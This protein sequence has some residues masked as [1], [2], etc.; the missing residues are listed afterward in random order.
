MFIQEFYS[1]MHAIN[2]SVPRFI[3]VFRGTCI[4]ITPEL[5]FEVLRV[6]SV[7]HPDFPSHHC[8]STIS[9]DKLAPLFREKVML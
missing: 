9:K 7:D 1:N 8:L 3:R 6:P 5:I 4:V 2:T